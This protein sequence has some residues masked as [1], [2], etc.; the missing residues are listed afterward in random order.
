MIINI[1]IKG[2]Y[3]DP[4]FVPYILAGKDINTDYKSPL[5]A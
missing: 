3:S 4:F 1:I 2:A 5:S